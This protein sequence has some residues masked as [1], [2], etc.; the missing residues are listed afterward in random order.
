MIDLNQVSLTLRNCTARSLVLLDEFG[1]GTIVSGSYPCVLIP[2][3]NPLGFP[4]A[5]IEADAL[6]PLL[7]SLGYLRDLLPC[8][9]STFRDADGAGLF[10][11][12]IKHL[13]ARG[14]HCPKVMT[15]THFHE[16]FQT[17]MLDP[18]SLSI[19]LVHMQVVLASS[20]LESSISDR[21]LEDRT[22]ETEEDHI[23][24]RTFEC[25]PQGIT[26]LYQYIPSA[27]SIRIG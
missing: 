15:T 2:V 3:L 17:D 23:D 6:R 24:Q 22:M 19:A 7:S 12:I 13:L 16:V 14:T 25:G 26:Y 1:K 10:C 9:S 5:W 21:D 8:T 27:L 4:W 11:G 18:T 20:T